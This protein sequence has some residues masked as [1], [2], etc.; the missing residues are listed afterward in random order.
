MKKYGYILSLLLV[1][2]CNYFEDKKIHATEDLVQEQL[3]NLDKTIIDKY[4]VFETCESENSSTDEEKICFV[5]TLSSHVSKALS[6]QDLVLD[7]ELDVNI[8]TTIE[9]AQSGAIRI[10]NLELTPQLTDQIPNI[11]ALITESVTNLP[12]IKP[13]YKKIQS[14]ELIA[15]TTQFTIPVRVLGTVK[16]DN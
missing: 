9:V 15:V 10:I 3:L 16:E 1:Y 12:E 14:G 4:P 13:A 7:E 5:T 2:S 6:E 11:E 8:Q